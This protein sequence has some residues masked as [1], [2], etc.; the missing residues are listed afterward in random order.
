MSGRIAFPN[1]AVTNLP[2]RHSDYCPLLLSS[3]GTLYE[4]SNRPFRYEVAWETHPGFKRLVKDQW[5]PRSNV[6]LVAN[7]LK[8]AV[9]TWNIT[10]FGHITHRKKHLVARLAGINKELERQWS[11]SLTLLEIEVK[12]ELG[13]ILVQEELLWNQKSRKAWIKDGDRNTRFFHIST[14]VGQKRNRIDRPQDE[15][16]KWSEDQMKLKEMAV[17]F[18]Q[19]L[20]TEEG[21]DPVGTQVGNGFPVLDK[22]NMHSAFVPILVPE[23]KAAIFGMGPLKAPGI[24]GIPAGFFQKPWAVISE[25]VIQFVMDV[26]QGKV[27]MAGINETLLVLIPKMENPSNLSQFRPISLCSVLYKTLTKIIANR[28]KPLLSALISPNQCSF[29]PER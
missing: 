24:N 19:K 25:G 22:Q 10:V 7:N 5:T 14:V 12:K 15:E 27:N 9:I 23:I 6:F 13:D 1:A 16:G 26:F 21:C 28:I 17:S 8:K 3:E 2:F 18:Y 11:H 29:I 20:F 4:A